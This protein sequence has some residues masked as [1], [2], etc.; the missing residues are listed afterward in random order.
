MVVRNRLDAVTAGEYAT[1][2]VLCKAVFW[3]A[4]AIGTVY[5]PRFVQSQALGMEAMQGMLRRATFLCLMI[6]AA[7]LLA[8]WPLSGLLVSIFAGDSAQPQM[9]EWLRL[10]IF[11]KIPAVCV[12]PF[13]AFFIARDSKRALAVLLGLLC[14]TFLYAQAFSRSVAG[15]LLIVFTGGLAMLLTSL[16]SV[17]WIGDRTDLDLRRD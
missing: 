7:A 12:T 8:V 5:L 6:S 3:F 14:L 9:N 11:A 4:S 13:L 17:R 1:V 2:A 15:L 10:M 16:L